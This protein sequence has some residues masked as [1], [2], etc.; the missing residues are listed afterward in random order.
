MKKCLH[1]RLAR[2]TAVSG[3][4]NWSAN[5]LSVTP[6]CLPSRIFVISDSESILLG[7]L[8]SRI[9]FLRASANP[10]RTRSQISARSNWAIEAKI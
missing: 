3:A 7:R 4:L 5:F 10:A 1:P 6:L 9:P 8:P 2:Y